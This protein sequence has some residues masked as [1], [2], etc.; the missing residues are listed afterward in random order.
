MIFL[1]LGA[2]GAGKGTQG[3]LI[4]KET[5][6][7][8]LSTGDSLRKHI[9]DNTELGKVAAG[10]V[11]AGNLVPDDL[12]IKIIKEELS[13]T[14][15]RIVLLDGFPRNISQCSAL[16]EIIGEEIC[17]ALHIHVEEEVLMDRILGRRLCSNCGA[18]FHQKYSPSKK[19]GKC[20]LCNSE[21]V[22]RPDDEEFKVKNRLK[23]Y[24]NET[25]HIIDYYKDR[26]LYHKINGDRDAKKVFL[27][28][29]S[30]ILKYSSIK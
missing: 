30:L 2:P 17:G 19:D 11:N 8:K 5:D 10:F 9:K 4:V 29:K 23:V 27:D 3:D 15:D 1:L 24:N 7:L 22:V 14:N 12:I 13:K 18:I 26:G 28:L 21:L 16:D 20:D 25:S 6:A